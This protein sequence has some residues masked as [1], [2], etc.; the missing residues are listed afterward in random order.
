MQAEEERREAAERAVEAVKNT[1]RESVARGAV[2]SRESE[3]ILLL[4]GKE[5]L[6]ELQQ[7][8]AQQQVRL[9]RVPITRGCFFLLF[10]RA[11]MVCA[12]P[13]RYAY[14]YKLYST[15]RCGDIYR[16]PYCRI[17]VM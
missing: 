5:Q 16:S 15:G 11:L 4:E 12:I 10:R 13:V 1:W 2:A 8:H 17:C 6:A 14:T 7:E 3:Q 9:G